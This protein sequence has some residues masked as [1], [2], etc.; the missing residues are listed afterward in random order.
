V[1]RGHTWAIKK[2]NI[3]NGA[4]SGYNIISTSTSKLY[5]VWT[6]GIIPTGSKSSIGQ[7]MV[8]GILK[9]QLT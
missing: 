8:Y 2:V 1:D 4:H 7:Y 9:A 5:L 6:M 3:K